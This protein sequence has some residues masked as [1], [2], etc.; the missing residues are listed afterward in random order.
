M[1]PE[2]F[3][4][5]KPNLVICPENDMF[6][7]LLSIYMLSN[8]EKLPSLSEVLLCSEN[9]SKDEV[10]LFLRRAIMFNFD[11]GKLIF[12]KYLLQFLL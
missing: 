1:F 11:T 8:K 9:T 12:N 4:E 10:E 3:D 7:T 6:S 2:E 5:G